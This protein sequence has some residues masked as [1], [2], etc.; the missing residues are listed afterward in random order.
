M[1]RGLSQDEIQRR[2]QRF[3]NM[4]AMSPD[5]LV[6]VD[7]SGHGNTAD[8][9]GLILQSECFT[10][11]AG[12]NGAGAGPSMFRMELRSHHS[13]NKMRIEFIRS[14]RAAPFEAVRER[15]VFTIKDHTLFGTILG[16]FCKRHG[17]QNSKRCL[18]LQ[19]RETTLTLKWSAS[20]LRSIREAY[21]GADTAPNNMFVVAVIFKD[22]DN[23]LRGAYQGCSFE[24]NGGEGISGLWLKG[25]K[26]TSLM[27][28]PWKEA[29]GE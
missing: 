22:N 5:D 29:T 11:C 26:H 8:D 3:V 24:Y 16:V 10:C 2:V 13:P 23:Q 9:E 4:C 6:V 27:N 21:H 7:Y 25:P 1:S 19:Y 14:G 20:V 15:M 18:S 28:G 17:I 12:D